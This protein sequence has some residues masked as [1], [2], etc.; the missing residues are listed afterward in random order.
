MRH[1]DQLVR[2]EVPTQHIT[3][4]TDEKLREKIV[5]FFKQLGFKYVTLDLQGFRTG[6]ANEVL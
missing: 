5:T 4:L 3:Q 1:H 6:S 2:I